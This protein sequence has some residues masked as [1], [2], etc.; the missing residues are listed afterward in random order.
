[1]VISFRYFFVMWRIVGNY[2]LV[3]RVYN[4]LQNLFKYD[5]QNTTYLFICWYYS[6][7]I[8]G[9]I[10][11]RNFLVRVH[12]REVLANR[13][14][15]WPGGLYLLLLSCQ[16]SL[17]CPWTKYFLQGYLL[18]SYWSNINQNDNGVLPLVF[19]PALDRG[20]YNTRLVNYI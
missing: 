19:R 11:E 8:V 9:N 10:S 4:S 15:N 14:Q 3:N 12:S 20:A 5:R 13:A 17:G 18:Q 7:K 16:P 6:H 1:M 2:F